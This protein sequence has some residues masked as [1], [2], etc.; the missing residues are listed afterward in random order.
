MLAFLVILA[1]IKMGYDQYTE[2]EHALDE[3]EAYNRE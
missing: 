2:K 1:L 3:F